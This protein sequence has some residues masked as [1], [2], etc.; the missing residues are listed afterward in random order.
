M[1]NYIWVD[2]SFP[3]NL[4]D[5]HLLDNHLLDNHHLFDNHHLLD[6]HIYLV[7]YCILMN[8]ICVD[9]FCHLRNDYLRVYYHYVYYRAYFHAYQ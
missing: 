7:Y 4:P 8:K 3:C 9:N 5:C 6:N 1:D 2:Y